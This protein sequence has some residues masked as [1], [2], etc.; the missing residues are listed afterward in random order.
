M[1][2]DEL[3]R[4]LADPDPRSAAFAGREGYARVAPTAVQHGSLRSWVV[5]YS[6]GVGEI[7]VGDATELLMQCLAHVADHGGG[8]VTLWRED[9]RPDDDRVARNVGLEP[10]RALHQMVVDL[11]LVDIPPVEVDA[12][13]VI[14]PFVPGRDDAAWLDLNNAAFAGHSE[15]GGWTRA[16]LTRRLREAWFDPTWFLVAEIDGQMV[17]F[18]WLRHHPA[19]G[20]TPESGEIYVIGVHP[21]A[22]GRG[23]G[24]AL[25]IAGFEL[26]AAQGVQNGMLYVS[27]DNDAALALYRSLGFTTSRTDRAYTAVV[28]PG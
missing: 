23:L 17:G 12:A 15:Q 5:G 13:L 1:L 28:M 18:N 19:H 9:A 6:P 16:V 26:V 25:A 2:G 3:R 11:P 24:R 20:D 7:G 21:S 27:A 10:D 4:D 8:H 14:R 22:A